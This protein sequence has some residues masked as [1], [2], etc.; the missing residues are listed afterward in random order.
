MEVDAL[1]KGG[2]SH[3]V[4]AFPNRDTA[5]I[6]PHV[7]TAQVSWVAPWPRSGSDGIAT[8]APRPNPRNTSASNDFSLTQAAF[9][10]DNRLDELD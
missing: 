3:N 5:L 7:T 9:R 10:H 1:G 8:A 6:R 4:A 2:R